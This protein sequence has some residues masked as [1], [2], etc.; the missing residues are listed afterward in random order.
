MR[1]RPITP[2]VALLLTFG[3]VAC[4]DTADGIRSDAEDLRDEVDDAVDDLQDDQ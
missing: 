1:I 2:L 4:D 3:V